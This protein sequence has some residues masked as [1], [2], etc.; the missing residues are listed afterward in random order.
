MS[1]PL[2]TLSLLETRILGVLVEKEH[3]VP[4]T[5]PLSLNALT[6]GCNQKNNRDPVMD[7]GD[8]E[9]LAALETLR[10]LSLVIES[11]GS[12]VTRY[13]QNVGRVL[14]VPSQAV[15]I[16]TALMLRGPQTVAELRANTER[17]HR[18][19]D[20]SSV[21]AFLAELSERSA[22]ALVAELP[23][24]AGT[25]ENRWTHLLSGMPDL[26]PP[27]LSAAPIRADSGLASRVVALEEEVAELRAELRALAGRVDALGL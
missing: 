12:R 15:A 7:V 11:S 26:P 23:R 27:S 14:Q 24:Q 20:A 1:S 9:V 4:D 16:L 22:G 17:L 8:A 13:A 2:P 10:G 21:E 19:T 18:F 25:R 3:T 6:S 5:Y